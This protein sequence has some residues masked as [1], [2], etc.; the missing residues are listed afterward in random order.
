[1]NIA[2]HVIAFI[3]GVAVG[4]AYR[5]HAEEWAMKHIWEKMH[6]YRIDWAAVF[7]GIC[8]LVLGGQLYFDHQRWDTYL[9]CQDRNSTASK[10]RSE[11]QEKWDDKN[12]K[13]DIAQSNLNEAFSNVIDTFTKLEVID[14]PLEQQEANRVFTALG[15]FAN[16][17]KVTGA[18]L[19]TETENLRAVKKANTLEDCDVP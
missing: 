4:L 19:V 7:L 8:V 9:D 12:A 15:V 14:T 10:A 17:A 1:M 11:A 5:K 16:R 6:R 18:Q 13:D 3:V 2:G